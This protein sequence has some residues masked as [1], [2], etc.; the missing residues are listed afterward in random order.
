MRLCPSASA[1]L[2]ACTGVAGSATKNRL[3]GMVVPLPYVGPTE[4]CCTAGRNTPS[5]VR[6]GGS[7][8]TGVLEIVVYCPGSKLCAGAPLSPRN[9]WFQTG[10]DHCPMLLLR[11][12]N[13][14]WSQV[15]TKPFSSSL[16]KEP[17]LTKPWLQ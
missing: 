16:A 11:V 13:C 2:I 14:C 10:F 9:T 1:A 7:C 15:H 12:K 8:E 4:S 3:N 17:P 6:Y 5:S